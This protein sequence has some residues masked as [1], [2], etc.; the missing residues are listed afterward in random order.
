MYAGKW[1]KTH[2]ET[3]SF[4]RWSVDPSLVDTPLGLMSG[5]QWILYKEEDLTRYVEAIRNASDDEIEKARPQIFQAFEMIR[6]FMGRRHIKHE[7]SEDGMF[8][9]NKDV[10]S[11]VQTILDKSMSEGLRHAD[12]LMS[13]PRD[14][15]AMFGLASALRIMS[16]AAY[17]TGAMAKAGT[18]G[19][20][21]WHNQ[22]RD[23]YIQLEQLASRLRDEVGPLYQAKIREIVPALSYNDVVD[24]ACK[25]LGSKVEPIT[26]RRIEAGIHLT[27]IWEPSFRMRNRMGDSEAPLSSYSVA[28]LRDQAAALLSDYDEIFH[29]PGFVNLLNQASAMLNYSASRSVDNNTVMNV[30]D[31]AQSEMREDQELA[32][33]ARGYSFKERAAV[34]LEEREKQIS[35]WQVSSLNTVRQHVA[36]HS[37]I[38]LFLASAAKAMGLR[39]SARTLE[40]Q[41]DGDLIVLR[42][43]DERPSDNMIVVYPDSRQKYFADGV[44]AVA[45]PVEMT[46]SGIPDL[47]SVRDS[48]ILK[49]SNFRNAEDFLTSLDEEASQEFLF[50]GKVL[51]ENL[52]SLG[53]R[54]RPGM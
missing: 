24:H 28:R 14:E 11:L 47:E 26:N 33:G 25:A 18:P 44:Y 31:Q 4:G 51:I 49:G 54:P 17:V 30:S 29:K 1:L 23:S 32:K 43:K 46:S 10:S 20:E 13:R 16:E 36:Y 45:L 53:S 42:Y 34:P 52:E 40:A 50:G 39:P 5:M 6:E 22:A 27:G 12:A 41:K 2:G 38:D 15:D 9:E 3:T 7:T 21:G 48:G 19:A 37:E 8:F 35:A